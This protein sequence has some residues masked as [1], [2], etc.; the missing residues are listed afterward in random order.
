MASNKTGMEE[1]KGVEQS[2]KLAETLIKMIATGLAGGTL[3]IAAA[4]Y[5]GEKLLDYETGRYERLEK[6]RE[7]DREEVKRITAA[8]EGSDY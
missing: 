3:V 6:Q 4:K 8:E 7:L 5:L 1:T 2:G